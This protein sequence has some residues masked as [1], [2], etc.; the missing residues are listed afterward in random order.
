MRGKTRSRQPMGSRRKVRPVALRGYTV[1]RCKYAGVTSIG[2]V[3][4]QTQRP[5]AGRGAAPGT[6]QERRAPCLENG[7]PPSTSG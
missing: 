4:P 2:F 6:P 3:L 7:P 5:A 1:R